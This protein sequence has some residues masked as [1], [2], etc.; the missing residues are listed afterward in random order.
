LSDVFQAVRSAEEG[1]SLRANLI[2][3]PSGLQQIAD[4]MDASIAQAFDGK[5]VSDLIDK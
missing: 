5:Q 2:E 1:N 3:L 4:A